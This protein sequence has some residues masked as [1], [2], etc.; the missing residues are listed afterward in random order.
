M[1]LT[2]T[3][4]D[5]IAQQIANA[6]W[7]LGTSADKMEA[8]RLDV[9]FRKMT[10]V[11]DALTSVGESFSEFRTLGDLTRATIQLTDDKL[12]I[13]GELVITDSGVTYFQALTE[14]L[15]E[16]RIVL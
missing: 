6:A 14:V 4:K 16:A 15:V 5:H 3:T 8:K 7:K 1:K 12:G 11:S 13:D 2:M 9:L 10:T